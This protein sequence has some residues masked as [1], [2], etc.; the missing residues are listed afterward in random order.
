MDCSAKPITREAV[1][2]GRESETEPSPSRPAPRRGVPSLSVVVNEA[3]SP[4]DQTPTARL[5]AEGRASMIALLAKLE[6]M[7]QLG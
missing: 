4:G 2:P 6:E 7:E 3:A 5:D 1:I